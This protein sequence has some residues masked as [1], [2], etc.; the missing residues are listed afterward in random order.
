[1]TIG[2]A[3]IFGPWAIATAIELILGY[4]LIDK[5][6]EIN[7]KIKENPE[8]REELSEEEKEE[9]REEKKAEGSMIFNYT[10]FSVLSIGASIALFIEKDELN[11]WAISFS[12]L[13]I[14]LLIREMRK[15]IVYGFGEWSK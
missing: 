15:A 2:W 7:Q 8:K 10:G 1:M 3:F 6:I 14:L 12:I 5:I 11:W 13:F 9:L 4:F